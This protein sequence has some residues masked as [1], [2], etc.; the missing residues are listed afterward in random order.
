MATFDQR[1]HS[2]CEEIALSPLSNLQPTIRRITAVAIPDDIRKLKENQRKM[3]ELRRKS[4][5][6]ELKSEQTAASRT[7]KT[8]KRH[9]ADMDR[10]KMKVFVDERIAYE[11]KVEAARNQAFQAIKEFIDNQP[12]PQSGQQED[13]L[14]QVQMM[15]ERQVSVEEAL[16]TSESWDK[17][18]KDL[19]D[20]NEMMCDY[21]N[22][23]HS[24]G[25][26]VDSIEG[27]ISAAQ[28][29][30]TEAAK[31][32][33]KV[34]TVQCTNHSLHTCKTTTCS[35]LFVHSF[36]LVHASGQKYIF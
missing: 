28:V 13:N 35:C 25:D 17:L 31:E 23:V 3:I 2:P 30:T 18:K 8:L 19:R 20:L 36:G 21:A 7:L 34:S 9:L 10:L 5:F 16:V 1:S 4:R 24:Q 32:I 29:R 14:P 15:A 33:G 22:L 11:I 27:N 26:M 12:E 6:K